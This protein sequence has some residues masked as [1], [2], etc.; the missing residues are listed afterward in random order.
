MS[1]VTIVG[2]DER[3]TRGVRGRAK[4]KTITH[5][6]SADQQS[7]H[8]RDRV[9]HRDQ[10]IRRLHGSVGRKNRQNLL[11]CRNRRRQC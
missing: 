11:N 2:R 5:Q 7:K 9:R 4:R 10:S 6:S 3:W 8:G 1:E